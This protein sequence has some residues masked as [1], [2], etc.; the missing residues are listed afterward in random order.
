MPNVRGVV[1]HL[2]YIRSNWTVVIGGFV[3][4][5]AAVLVGTSLMQAGSDAQAATYYHNGKYYTTSDSSG[6]YNPYSQNTNGYTYSNQYRPTYSPQPQFTCNTLSVSTTNQ[7]TYRFTT[8]ASAT[9]G[10][11]IVG[12]RY[13]YG[14]GGVQN[15]PATVDH[16][17]NRAGTYTARAWVQF[18]VNG[19]DRWITSTGCTRTV[20]VAGYPTPTPTYSPQPQLACNNLSVTKINNASYRFT[21]N[22]SSNYG[23]Q[24]V[25]YRYEYGDGGVQNGP[26]TVDHT[27]NRAGTYTARAWVLY[28]VN[29]Q[30]RWITS[31]GCTKQV[32]VSGYPTPT[33]TYTPN[34]AYACNSLTITKVGERTYRFTT[35][36]SAS[37]GASVTGY[38]YE[39]GDGG[40][41]NGPA[42]VDHTYNRAGTYTARAWVW[43]SVNGQERWVTS[44]GCTKQFAVATGSSSNPCGNYYSCNTPTP[45]ASPVVVTTGSNNS[46]NNNNSSA[47]TATANV[48]VNQ[49]AP[50]ETKSTISTASTVTAPAE[51]SSTVAPAAVSELPKTGPQDLVV[52]GLGFGSMLV[53]GSAYLNSRR[54]LLGAFLKK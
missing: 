11:Q 9:S 46:N 39:Y 22:A 19:Q 36:A 28:R 47:A 38:R 43:L 26:A 24:I 40:V 13:E 3:L 29:G 34:P 16:T 53:A 21:T 30:D 25:G 51:S 33:P 44:T 17:Y 18:R 45:S 27:Y 14:D 20:S 52:G 7:R 41:Q 37:N 49:A 50:A 6:S 35:S 15:G 42:T 31:T 23:A 2:K 32:Q 48:V 1:N 10:A 8:S 12:Y 54:E 4:V 5:L